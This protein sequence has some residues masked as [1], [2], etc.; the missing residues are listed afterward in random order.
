VESRTEITLNEGQILYV[1]A[2]P[3][4]NNSTTGKTF[5]LSDLTI[6]GM[7]IN[8]M[9]GN[10]SIE[11]LDSGNNLY[12]TADGRRL[13]KP[14]HGLNIVKKDNGKARKEMVK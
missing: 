2:Y 7:A 1:R 11:E 13:S 4:Y 5:C 9:D 10:N 6:H 8:I 3:W 12:Y 14:R